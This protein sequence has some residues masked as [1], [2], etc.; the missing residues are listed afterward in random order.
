VTRI[1]LEVLPTPKDGIAMATINGEDFV[2]AKVAADELSEML[3]QMIKDG[4]QC[5]WL[6]ISQAPKEFAGHPECSRGPDLWGY[7]P[8]CHYVT[9]F[10]D[11]PYPAST[12]E[13]G[14]EIEAYAGGW[15]IYSEGPDEVHP[16][17]FMYLP[18]P[19]KE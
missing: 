4:C 10:W 7:G 9:M 19:P 8:D 6:P 3:I 11:K 18:E 5:T 1:I 16:T 17:H 2:P 15:R 12:T 14:F 13:S